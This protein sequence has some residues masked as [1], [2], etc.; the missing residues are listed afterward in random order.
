MDSKTLLYRLRIPLIEK[1]YGKTAAEVLQTCALVAE[2]A[3]DHTPDQVKSF[4]EQVRINP[5]VWSRLISLHKDP[6]L[7]KHLEHLPSC[8]TA[9]YAIHRMKD[10]EIEASV[11]QGVITP[12]V[13]SHRILRW[14]QDNRSISGEIVPPWRC[15]VVFDQEIDSNDFRV[16]RRRMDQI[17][18]EYCAKLISES[19]YI[20]Q[21]PKESKDKRDLLQRLE[22]KILELAMP[23]FVRMKE[24]QRSRAGV[25]QVEDFLHV[26]LITFG[27]VLRAD[28]KYFAGG[29]N[30][31][32]PIYVYR[33]ALEF[34]RTQSRSQRFNCKR[35]LRQLLEAQPDLRECIHEVMDVYMSR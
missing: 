21:D 22:S 1:D 34:L 24:H 32:Q 5:Q 11:Q 2:F 17:A 9:L 25:A 18:Q 27:S 19:D 33:L 20:A 28:A 30:S 10:E 35:R 7:R 13:S 29:K 16:M 14:T 6:R 4:Q 15:L 8:Y 26:D 12:T 31:Y 23:M 3:Q